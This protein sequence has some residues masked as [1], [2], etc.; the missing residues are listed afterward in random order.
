MVFYSTD[1]IKRMKAHYCTTL[2]HVSLSV[3]DPQ[4]DKP[5]QD[6]FVT[7]QIY[8]VV[9]EADGKRINTHQVNT[10]KDLFYSG[11]EELNR[12]I[13]LRGEPGEGKST[14]AAKLVLD[15]CNEYRSPSTHPEKGAFNDLEILSQ[16]NALFFYRIK[17]FRRSEDVTEINKI[18]NN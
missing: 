1:L 17:K 18:T 2:S 10:Y 12:H 13:F 4:L 15:W 16:F 11:E 7:P 3:L 6:L 14:F 9:I 5:L 8:R